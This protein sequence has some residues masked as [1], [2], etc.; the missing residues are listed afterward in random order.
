MAASAERN[1]PKIKY[2]KSKL[3]TKIQ[4]EKK[5]EFCI[6]VLHFDFWFLIFNSPLR[7]LRSLW[8]NH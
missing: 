5:F 4:N 1:N 3:Q 8:C 2:Q 7:S 6:V